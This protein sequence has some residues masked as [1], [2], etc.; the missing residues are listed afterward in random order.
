MNPTDVVTLADA[1]YAFFIAASAQWSREGEVLI[2]DGLQLVATKTRYPVGSFNCALPLDEP[3]DAHRA[4]RWLRAA[5]EFFNAR[6]RG[7]SILLRGEKDGALGRLCADIGMEKAS[8]APGMALDSPTA[9]PDLQDNVRIVRL[10][11]PQQLEDFANVVAAGFAQ[12]KL[13]EEICRGMF[14]HPER[15]LAPHVHFYVAYVDDR[16]AATTLAIESHGI[17]GIYWVATHPDMQR[18]GLAS[19]L[20]RHASNEAFDL[21]ARRVILQ[22]SPFGEPVYRRLGYREFCRYPCYFFSRSKLRA[23][24]S[25]D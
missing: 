9:P 14:E 12:L 2:R 4:E 5:I 3:G 25:K 13:P 23:Y 20:M 7:C 8:E 11:S 21:G 6:D 18:R 15:L 10:S 1:N 17:S 19:A 22:A 16:P 24:L